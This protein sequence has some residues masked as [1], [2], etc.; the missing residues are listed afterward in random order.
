MV[1]D[2][3]VRRA[4]DAATDA[5]EYARRIRQQAVEEHRQAAR[6]EERRAD[7]LN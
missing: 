6:D 2:Q 4:D 3:D 7:E 5:G 1:T